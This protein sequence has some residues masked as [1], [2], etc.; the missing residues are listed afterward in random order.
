MGNKTSDPQYPQIVV[1]VWEAVSIL[2]RNVLFLLKSLSQHL[3]S[4]YKVHQI[5]S[6]HISECQWNS[7]LSL[8]DL[9]HSGTCQL[10]R[11]EEGTIE[12]LQNADTYLSNQAI[13]VQKI[14]IFLAG[15][16][17]IQNT[18]NFCSRDFHTPY[19]TVILFLSLVF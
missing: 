15:S 2:R 18:F 13:A 6:F 19:Y 10:F 12:C 7:C 9:V 1:N 17:R 11:D 8:C 3:C 4:V 14:K 16:V 5:T